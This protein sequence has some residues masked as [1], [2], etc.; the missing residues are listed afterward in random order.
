[1]VIS[2]PVIWWLSG[3]PGASGCGVWTVGESMNEG[4]LRMPMKVENSE[5][6]ERMHGH[7]D[8]SIEA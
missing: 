1:M 2:F 3:T 7:T 6:S 8:K 5:L 4:F